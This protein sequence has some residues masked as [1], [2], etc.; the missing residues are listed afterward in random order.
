MRDQRLLITGLAT[1]DSIAY[2]V[3]ERALLA[4]AHVTLTAPPGDVER[5]RAAAEH[6]PPGAHVVQVDLTRDE[7]VDAL[8]EHL[9]CAFRP[10]DGALDAGPATAA[11]LAALARAVAP[12]F[13][14]GGGA[15]LG[16][17]GPEGA[18]AALT[19]ERRRLADALRPA[20]HRVGLVVPGPDDGPEGV[21]GAV[22]LLLAR[23]VAT[24]P[25][26]VPVAAL[27]P[28]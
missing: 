19:A 15:L 8:A 1:T 12:R 16:L 25:A 3:A 9:R 20:G 27:G 23:G 17:A 22:L 13:P 28:A 11:S 2:A 14:G 18:D 6:L 10:L 7:D 24:P 21:A 5:C 4:G 26:P